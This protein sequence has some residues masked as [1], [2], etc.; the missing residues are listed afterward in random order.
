MPSPGA[1]AALV[2]VLG[3]LVIGGCGGSG[4]GAKTV[5]PIILDTK[6]VERAIEDSILT[7]RGITAQVDCPSGVHQGKGLTFLC[8]ATTRAGRTTFVVHQ[9]DDE[10]NVV[11][12]AR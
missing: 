4:S 1:T 6:R 7:K 12:A 8:V 11:Y 2:V 9:R 5:A 3:G 10:G